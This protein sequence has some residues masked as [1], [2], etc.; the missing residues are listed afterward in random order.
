MLR[1][2][3]IIFKLFKL[4]LDEMGLSVFDLAWRTK[5][6]DFCGHSS[7]SVFSV[8]T[9]DWKCQ[10][11]DISSTIIASWGTGGYSWFRNS[12]TKIHDW[13]VWFESFHTKRNF[14]HNLTFFPKNIVM[15]RNYSII[16]ED[17]CSVV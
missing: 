2:K 7:V 15:R 13:T 5:N 4:P 6:V 9:V 3:A 17:H 10:W 16:F 14:V 8:C 1:R 11:Y 12:D